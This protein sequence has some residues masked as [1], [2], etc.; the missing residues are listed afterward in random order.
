MSLKE[1]LTHSKIPTNIKA[2]VLL[3]E[4]YRFQ[5]H[6][7]KRK[8]NEIDQKYI[9]AKDVI[10]TSQENGW[11]TSCYLSQC[12]LF[13]NAIF[14]V[15]YEVKRHQRIIDKLDILNKTKKLF[16]DPADSIDT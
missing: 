12:H 15:D 11:D 2:Y 13:H 16:I 6:I 4:S 9:I 7:Y 14:D 3:S 8:K 1:Q 5:R 10:I